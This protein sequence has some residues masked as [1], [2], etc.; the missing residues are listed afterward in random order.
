MPC[1]NMANK[2]QSTVLSIT[3]GHL[4]P[5]HHADHQIC[6]SCRLQ[7]D[8]VVHGSCVVELLYWKLRRKLP[9]I[10][11]GS[12]HP[13]SHPIRNHLTKYS[14]NQLYRLA[15][16]GY[17]VETFFQHA[18]NCVFNHLRISIT[19]DTSDR[20]NFPR[21]YLPF[22]PLVESVWQTTHYRDRRVKNNSTE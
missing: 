13:P 15:Q 7:Q 17:T 16:S 5:M 14:D 21:I 3:C 20:F 2:D 8:D 12:S 19:K 10:R 18:L 11:P 6:I 9:R 4:K 1:A 22:I